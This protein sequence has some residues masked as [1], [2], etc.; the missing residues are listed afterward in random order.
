VKLKPDWAAAYKI[1]G[2][3]FQAKEEAEAADRCYSR[4]IE[5][6]PEFAEVWA[7]MGTVRAQQQRW[8]DNMVHEL[9]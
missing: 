4:A 8:T 7:N 5:I 1:L 9:V 2:N 3:A 6:D